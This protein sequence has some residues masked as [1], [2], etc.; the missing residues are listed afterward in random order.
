MEE[1]D[2]LP[3]EEGEMMQDPAVMED[4]QIMHEQP[5]ENGMDGEEANQL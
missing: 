4:P 1:D 3:P 2:N 5:I